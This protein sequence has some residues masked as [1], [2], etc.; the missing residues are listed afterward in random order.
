[1]TLPYLDGVL[2][3]PDNLRR[4]AEAVRTALA[5]PVG[6]QAAAVARWGSLV[7]FGMGAS[8][9]AAA[10]FAAALR[11]DGLPATAVSAADLHDGVPHG[12]AAA[13]LGISQ[14]GRSRETVEALAAAPAARLALTNHPD[15]PLGAAADTVLALGCAE[16]TAVTTLSYTAT[17]QA[18]GLLAERMSGQPRTDWRLLPDLATQVL[19]RDAEPLVVALAG[20]ACVDVVAA[21]TRLATAGAAALLL[22]EAAH[23]PTASFTTREYLHGPL[24]TAGP[25]RS[26]VLFGAA[27]EVPLALDLARYGADV[28]LVTDSDADVPASGAL[29]V[30]R[31]PRLGGLGGCVLDILPVQLAAH[32]LAQHAGRP[33]E[34]RHMPA[35]T[36]L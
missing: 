19:R 33:I 6:A 35:D 22:R 4:S 29:L 10:G 23:L 5:G 31:L 7:A 32:A 18:L 17:L 30:V 14:S 24:E 27:R 8:A 16:D 34:L 36:K 3:Q 9:H 28:V 20:A 13:F 2:A 12:L 11:A 15:G 21:G 26:V 1:M 25:G